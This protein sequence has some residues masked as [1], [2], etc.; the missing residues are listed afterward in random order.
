MHILSNIEM[1]VL[2]KLFSLVIL[3]VPSTAAIG[4]EAKE[5]KLVKA[6]WVCL[7]IVTKTMSDEDHIS[8]KRS[9]IAICVTCTCR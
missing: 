7:G 5:D 2:E 6:P 1:E 3:V 9:I 4:H 8:K